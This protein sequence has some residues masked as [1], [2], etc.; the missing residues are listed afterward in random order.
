MKSGKQF[1][2]NL[3]GYW[4]GFTLYPKCLKGMSA[5]GSSMIGFVS[6][7]VVQAAGGDWTRRN[8]MQDTEELIT[9]VLGKVV[10]S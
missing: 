5:D 10:T 8:K 7:P 2:R 6:K 4:K 9:D 1:A 3:A